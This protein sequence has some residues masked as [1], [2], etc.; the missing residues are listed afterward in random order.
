MI[1]I[2]PAFILIMKLFALAVAVLI[3]GAI[4]WAVDHWGGE[5]PLKL[6]PVVTIPEIDVIHRGSGGNNWS[7]WTVD[8]V[9]CIV[10]RGVGISCDWEKE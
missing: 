1:D 2:G 10:Y 8:G 6:P 4:I 3:G 5:D 7:T 9:D